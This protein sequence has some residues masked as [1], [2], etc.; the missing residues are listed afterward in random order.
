MISVVLAVGILLVTG[1]LGV[2]AE[3]VVAKWLL[4]GDNLEKLAKWLGL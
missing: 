2:V 1:L 3:I 4:H